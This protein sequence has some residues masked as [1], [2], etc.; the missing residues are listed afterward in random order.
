MRPWPSVLLALSTLASTVSAHAAQR[1]LALGDSYTIGEGVTAHE[2][3]PEQWARA[4]RAHGVDVA[5]PRIIAHTG[6]TTDELA[7]AMD[8]AEPLGRWDRVS[9]LIGVNNQYRGRDLD[10]YRKEFTALLDRTIGLAGGQARH[11]WVL[12]IPDWGVTAF[13]RDGGHDPA[14]IAREIDAFNAVGHEVAKSRGVH[15]VDITDL[16][17]RHGG[18]V[19]MLVDD[20]LHPSGPMYG[21]W[22]ERLIGSL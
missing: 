21:L 18:N 6:W 12:S 5:P 4:L 7:A 10:N 14:R 17:R 16:T 9:L 19:S 11:V 3:W 20:G 2:R 22:V 15:W 8:A 13:A 1:Y